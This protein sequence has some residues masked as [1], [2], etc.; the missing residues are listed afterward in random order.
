[1]AKTIY[2][3]IESLVE[4]F[5]KDNNIEV[6]E[7]QKKPLYLRINLYIILNGFKSCLERKRRR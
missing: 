5:C 2:N 1:M 4:E 7:L 6:T 3:K